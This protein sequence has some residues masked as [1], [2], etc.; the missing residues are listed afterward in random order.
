[1]FRRNGHSGP[2]GAGHVRLN[3]RPVKKGA[4]LADGDLLE[5]RDIPEPAD[6]K[7]QPNPDLPLKILF[8]DHTVL[9]LDIVP[10][11]L[12]LVEWG[13][14]DQQSRRGGGSCPG[15]P[16]AR[17]RRGSRPDVTASTTMGPRTDDHQHTTRRAP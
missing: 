1:M 3:H 9:A 17:A 15:G 11:G 14:S 5:C 7:L 16:V 8:E 6:L 13:G 10:V 4:K 2:A 12:P